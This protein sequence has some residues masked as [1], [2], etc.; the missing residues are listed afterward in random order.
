MSRLEN[1]T[2][3]HGSPFLFKEID[4]SAGGSFKDFG[5]GFYLSTN[6]NHAIS[7]GKRNKYIGHNRVYLYT[8]V[9]HPDIS[10][11]VNVKVFSEPDIDWLNFVMMNRKNPIVNSSFDVVCGPTAD[12][13]MFNVI[14]RYEIGYYNRMY[15]DRAYE[16]LI[17]DLKPYRYPHQVCILTERAKQLIRLVHI[18]TV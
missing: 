10:K 18:D 13:R 14:R 7:A 1:K 8:Y 3:Y 16:Y 15:G 12:A 6:K 17:S 2:L 4:L 5:K 9:V 11:L